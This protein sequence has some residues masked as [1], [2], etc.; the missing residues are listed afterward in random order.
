MKLH[1]HKLHRRY[2]TVERRAKIIQAE[3]Y[4]PIPI[5][6]E[7]CDMVIGACHGRKV[8]L[9]VNYEKDNQYF[10]SLLRFT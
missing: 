10:L 2:P 1:V 8:K 6:K 5:D 9:N 7:W 4:L 3:A